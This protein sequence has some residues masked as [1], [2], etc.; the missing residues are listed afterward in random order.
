[1]KVTW[2]AGLS[3][4]K[5]LVP[6]S[7]FAGGCGLFSE[8]Q[9]QGRNFSAGAYIETTLKNLF[10]PEVLHDAVCARPYPSQSPKM[11]VSHSLYPFHLYL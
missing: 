6:L 11:I 9:E 2:L 8:P 10:L 5:N 1:M 4:A 3:G 7:V